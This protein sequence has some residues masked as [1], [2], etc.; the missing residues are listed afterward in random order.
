MSLPS[1]VAK[2]A[3][4]G[5]KVLEAD[6]KLEGTIEVAG[7]IMNKRDLVKFEIEKALRSGRSQADVSK[8]LKAQ[9]LDV[10]PE[11]VKQQVAV[12]KRRDPVM[13][14]DRRMREMEANFIIE[15]GLGAGRSWDEIGVELEAAGFKQGSK[16]AKIAED[17]YRKRLMENS[18]PAVIDNGE[19][20]ALEARLAQ[21]KERARTEKTFDAR[22]EVAFV[23]GLLEDARKGGPMAPEDQPPVFNPEAEARA[24]NAQ[25]MGDSKMSIEEKLIDLLNTAKEAGRKRS[26]DLKGVRA[27]GAEG[28]AND[29]FVQELERLVA[30]FG[31]N[32][33]PTGARIR[34]NDDPVQGP[35]TPPPGQGE[36]PRIVTE[37]M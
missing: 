35:I 4:A 7:R 10:D 29:P 13:K 5:K 22:D 15:K 34:Q 28:A 30:E 32:K 26:E 8:S 24:A 12:A 3:K 33:I 19:I 23:E 6:K 2:V 20:Q 25:V 11:W 18:G 37:P 9:G 17:N 1:V 14:P 36:L 21:A 27:E 31:K 16:L